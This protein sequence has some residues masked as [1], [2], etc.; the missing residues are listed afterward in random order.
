MGTREN[1]HRLHSPRKRLPEQYEIRNCPTYHYGLAPALQVLALLVS[2]IL[3]YGG[4][5]KLYILV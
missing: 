3:R 2:G 1:R 4:V 5:G